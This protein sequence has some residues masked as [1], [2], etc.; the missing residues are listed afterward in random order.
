MKMKHI[1]VFII[2]GFIGNV[3]YAQEDKPSKLERW[4]RLV[5]KFRSLSYGQWRSMSGEFNDAGDLIYKPLA[6]LLRK[7]ETGEGAWRRVE[8]NQR[9]VAWILG[10]VGT[11]K[12]VDFLV[13]MLPDTT[14]NLWGRIEAAESLG[15]MNAVRAV[16]PLLETFKDKESDTQLRRYAERAL[17]DL[18]C[19]KAVSFLIKALNEDIN[20]IDMGV[21]Y[22]L[23]NIGSD[24]AV[25]G[26]LYA[27]ECT[28]NYVR[29]SVYQHLRRLRP[30]KEIAFLLLALEDSYWGAREVAVKILSEKG[31]EISGS[32]VA[33]FENN[34]TSHTGRWETIR[35]LG[36]MKPEKYTKLFLEALKDEDRR[37]RD[38][39]AVVLGRINASKT[40]K[41]LIGLLKDEN[42]YV[43]EEAAWVLGE[44]K[45]EK[46]IE[47]LIDML[48]DKDSGWMAAISLGKIGSE[49]SVKSLIGMLMVKEI[50][51][52]RAAAWALG[53]IQSDKAVEPLIKAVMDEDDEVRMLSTL[54]LEMIGTHGALK[55]VE[56]FKLVGQDKQIYKHPRLDIQVEAPSGWKQLPRPE[57]RL[58]YEIADTEENVHVMLWYTATMQDA[59]GYLEKMA[60]MK[61]L[62]WEGEPM[63]VE[64][65]EDDAW[66]VDAT[67]IVWG[68]DAR[69]FLTVIQNG[70]DG[71]HVD[72]NALYIVMIW[73]PEPDFSRHKLQM[74]NILNSVKF[75]E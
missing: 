16:D 43:R 7:E 67:G 30:E 40:V 38:E 47:F 29:G 36:K 74:A 57:D 13:D 62:H 22:A 4:S 41:P 60:D 37:I 53:K 73:C 21:I 69:V 65:K 51:Q 72:H 58:I 31:E 14:L 32:L 49:K 63:V 20:R 61:G 5:Q 26:L 39:S 55:A 70:Y 66:K 25:D 18:Q 33:L 50:K 19:Q 6:D 15:R 34:K 35:I 11:E 48:D 46:A 10:D 12:A 42:P 68:I 3:G 2:F 71:R 56:D 45:P 9:S 23:G 54:A 27:L 52:R 1:I 59:K 28:E 24:D 75:T 17:G 8:W 44:M 64:G